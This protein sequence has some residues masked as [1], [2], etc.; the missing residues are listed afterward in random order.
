[1][2]PTRQHRLGLSLAGVFA[3]LTALVAVGWTEGLDEA[4]HSAMVELETGLFVSIARG[5]HSVGTPVGTTAIVVG[6]VALLVLTKR[7]RAATLWGSMVLTG[8]ALSTVTKA[9]VGRT[10]PLEGLVSESSASYPSGH[11]MVT[12]TATGLGLALVCGMLWPHR[13]RLFVVLATGFIVAMAWSRTYLRAHWLTDVVGGAL[14][15]AAVVLVIAGF[16]RTRVQLDAAVT[17]GPGT[18]A[19]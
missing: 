2:A 5:L 3:F 6:G 14:F 7:S 15:G 9:V 19:T 11:V 17:A 10:R 4:W 12:A 8:L 18:G 16:A 1:M 13:A